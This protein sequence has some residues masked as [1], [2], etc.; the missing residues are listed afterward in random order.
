MPIF[1][2]IPGIK[3][4]SKGK[5]AGWLGFESLQMGPM[6]QPTYI[7]SASVAGPDIRKVTEIS[8]SRKTD[9]I[10]NALF[11]LSMSGNSMNMVY[12]MAKETGKGDMTAFLRVEL[13]QAY[14]DSFSVSGGGSEGP[15]DLIKFSFDS[16]KLTVISSKTPGVN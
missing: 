4:K 1:G 16:L 3:G 5:Y 10:S 15:M 11:R 14:I 6:T 12:E 7:G 13:Q 2:K 8:V 9:E